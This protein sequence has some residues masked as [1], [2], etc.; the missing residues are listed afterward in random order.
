MYDYQKTN[1]IICT[2]CKS[3]VHFIFQNELALVEGRKH[4][5]TTREIEL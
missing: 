1:T 2:R 3:A 5:A 4:E